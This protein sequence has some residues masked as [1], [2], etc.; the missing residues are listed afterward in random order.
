MK[1]AY[2]DVNVDAVLGCLLALRRRADQAGRS[3]EVELIDAALAAA[4]P[5][6]LPGAVRSDLRR[7]FADVPLTPLQ[8]ETLTY[9]AT[10][11][12][13]YGYAPTLEEIAEQA[14]VSK[15][16]IYQRVNELVNRGVL[17]R[18]PNVARGMV[19]TQAPPTAP[20]RR[21]AG[22]RRAA[23]VVGEN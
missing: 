21:H 20:T 6:A 16:T 14:G 3:D 5:D 18:Y 7:R 11:K 1:K 13:Q 23:E 12:H 10:Y 15:V 22:V 19:V 9:I 17:H 2:G 4:G 8:W